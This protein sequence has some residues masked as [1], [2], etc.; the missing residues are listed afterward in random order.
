MTKRADADRLQNSE[1]VDQLASRFLESWVQANGVSDCRVAAL[2]G[3][4]CFVILIEGAF[5]QAERLLAQRE[6]ADNPLRQYLNG[7]MKVIGEETISA[8]RKIAGQ[9]VRSV[10]TDV[11]F[12]QGWVMW[13]VRLADPQP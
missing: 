6:R 3:D 12:E 9:Q 5:T 13:Y 4:G 1:S 7:L 10:G 2:T 11:N 8:D